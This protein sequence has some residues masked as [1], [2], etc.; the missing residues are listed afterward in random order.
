MDLSVPQKRVARFGLY[1]ADLQEC[2]LTKGGLRIKL[3]DQPFQVLALLLEHPGR[4]V[5]REEIRHKLWS[6]NT[7]VEFDD[8]LNNAVKKLRVAL[9]D[10]ADNP[11]FIETVPRRGYRFVAPVD[12]PAL[13]SPAKAAIE[14]PRPL[15]P[16]PSEQI[17][18]S[19]HERVVP[20]ETQ[21]RYRWRWAASG[22]GL[23]LVAAGLYFMHLHRS[24]AAR[25]TEKDSIV[26]ADFANTT[27]DPV[28]DG[29]LKQALTVELGQSPYLNVASEFKVSDTLRRMGR[30]PD[31]PLT[32]DLARE[33]CLRMGSRAILAGSI[34]SLG[35]RY[36][37]GLE[38]L[39]CASGDTLAQ[40]EAE[41][42]S[43]DG[44]LK[45]LD[46][47]ASQLRGK[48]GESLSS[49]EKYDF[50]VD[51][52]TNSLEALKAYSLGLKT[53][54]ERGEA[55][56]IPFF[57]HAIQLDSGFALAYVSLGTVYDNLGEE[58]LAEEFLAKAYSERD[59]VTERE[60][61]YITAVYHSDVTGDL[62]KE[63]EVCEL[64]AHTYRRDV[65]A[66]TLLGTVYDA[67]GQH[68]KARVEFEEALH[69]D[70]DSVLNYGNVAASDVAL[71]RFDEAQATLR[72]G[73]AHGLD[74]VIIHENLYSLA[75]LRA[76]NAEMERQVAWGAG[77]PGAEDQLLSQQSD[78][79]AYFGKFRRARELS[80]RAVDSALRADAKETAAIWQVN[81]ALREIEV[82]NV[83]KARQAV[84]A[85]QALTPSREVNI[86]AALVLTR[87]GD[88]PRAKAMIDKLAN[89][90]PS[91]TILK[92]YWL[93][94][95]KASLEVE[96]GNAE[97]A[98]SLLQTAAPYELG[99]AS[100][101]SNMYPAYV[102]G[103]AYLL[104]NNGGAA[105]A[106]FKKLLDHPG[107]VQND[108]LGVLSHLQLAR[109]IA[110]TG[111]K[112]G[113]RNQ[114][115]HFLSL[116]KDADPDIPALKEAK[117]EY[118]KLQ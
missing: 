67:E 102:R 32:R 74:G 115:K 48:I 51:A 61:Y 40:G 12:F 89:E 57:R 64:W 96:S 63:R 65:A 26:V 42:R 116:W 4:V 93:P 53:V 70:P 28:F 50:P 107:I 19:T 29:T 5:T 118:A 1:E 94:T 33:V 34:A 86:L 73:Q 98:L 3:Q 6:A 38:A 113:A 10:A 25:L 15:S 8:G 99:E 109:A 46:G 69:L 68:E 103:Q 66:R 7:F 55:D 21:S 101:I 16:G 54:R 75:F 79:E 85:A 59:R 9:S 111:D 112:D 47:L 56:A 72:K 82:G 60:R 43:K 80:R 58:G 14:G 37:L 76:D 71:N 2:V 41:S 23:L 52:T 97:S 35:G 24:S 30:S 77:K 87:T 22:V 81:A 88:S 100:Y 106:E 39:G 104:A 110:A 90:H 36:I 13:T 105:A 91:Y 114:Y 45:A 62:E 49:L 44:V 92:V 27:G 84:D 11:R 17:T 108:I 83:A 18:A 31:E 95:L 78:T 117:A 20:E